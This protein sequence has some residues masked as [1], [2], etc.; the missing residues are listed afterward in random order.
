MRD[1]N[2]ELLEHLL[3]KMSLNDEDA[4]HALVVGAIVCE[5]IRSGEA[6]NRKTLCCKLVRQLEL[7]QSREEERTYYRAIRLLFSQ[8]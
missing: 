3:K 6:I 7:C 5:L 1:N 4:A 8:Q 2:S